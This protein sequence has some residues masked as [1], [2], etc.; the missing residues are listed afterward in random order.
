MTNKIICPDIGEYMVPFVRFIRRPEGRE[1]AKSYI[2]GLVI[3]GERKSVEP[4]SAR[5]NASERGMQKLLTQVKFDEAGI[6]SCFQDMM[7]ERTADPMGIFVYDDTGFPKKGKESVC[8]ARQYCGASGKTDNCQ[9]GV[10]MTYIGQGVAWPYKMDLFV[11]KSWD[12]DNAECISRRKKTKM[13]DELHHREK[14]RIVL[15]Q[16]DEANAKGVPHAAVV[17]D[18]WYGDIP[19]FREE[20]VKR[21]ENYIVGV[22][23]DTRIVLE[24]PTDT[25]LLSAKKKRG[26][27]RKKPMRPVISNPIKV[28]ELGKAIADDAWEQLELRQNSRNKP[29][30]V[31]AVSRRV[32]PAHGWSNGKRHDEL[33]LLIERRHESGGD[34]ELRYFFS[35]MPPTMSTLNLAKFNHMRYWIEH[36]YQQ[37]K[38]ELGLDHHEGRS[39]T[40]WH[41]HVLFTFLAFGYL[42]LARLDSVK[43]N[44]KI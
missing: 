32:Y 27:P 36:G 25:Q 16:L 31:E 6:L 39:W 1:L 24:A 40:G 30:M 43:K 9:I 28:S 33:W 14:W 10:S 17:A 19:E 37:L 29:L 44:S 42:T 38:G 4:M 7:L 23:S 5:V 41:R 12:S 15:D 13:P 20:L 21:G 3:E 34:F 8:V 2:C 22:H 26:R 18:S 35:N 11:P